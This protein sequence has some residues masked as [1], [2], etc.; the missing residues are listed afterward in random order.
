MRLSRQCREAEVRKRSFEEVSVF[1]DVLW[2]QLQIL[3]NGLALG[4]I[5]IKND[6]AT[7]GD[8]GD[9]DLP[10][11][12]L[13]DLEN[14]INASQH[15]ILYDWSTLTF[16]TSSIK[17]AHDHLKLSASNSSDLLFAEPVT[18]GGD[19]VQPHPFEVLSL[20]H[21]RDS[22]GIGFGVYSDTAARIILSHLHHTGFYERLDLRMQLFDE[23]SKPQTTF[24][25]FPL[26]VGLDIQ[27]IR[28]LASYAQILAQCNGDQLWPATADESVI[29]L[30]FCGVY[31]IT[32]DDSLAAI[33][34]EYIAHRQ[35][36]PG[37]RSGVDT[38]PWPSSGSR[39]A[40]TR[41]G[42]NGGDYVAYRR[43]LSSKYAAKWMLALHDQ[44]PVFYSAILYELVA[45][46][47]DDET[48]YRD[49]RLD[50][51]SEK[52]DLRANASFADAA[53]RR[54]IRLCHVGL[55]FTAFDDL[56]LNWLE[57]TS[58]LW[59]SYEAVTSL[60]RL[61]NEGESNQRSTTF[62][63]STKTV[64]DASALQSLNPWGVVVR[65][66][67]SH[68]D[69]LQR[70]L[71]WLRMFARS[72]VDIPIATVQQFASLANRH[73]LSLIESL[74]LTA[75][76]LY[77]TWLRSLGRQELLAVV[78]SL[79]VRLAPDIVQN[80]ITNQSLPD[81][82]S[83][84]RH[85]L[86]TILLLAGCERQSLITNG[87][88]LENEVKDLTPRRRG[89]TR[90]T[91]VS[92]PVHLRPEFV[93]ILGKYVDAGVE[94]ISILIAKFLSLFVSECRL[95]ESYE[96]DNFILRNCAVLCSCTWAFYGLQR[97]EL[98]DVRPVLFL[99]VLSVDSQPFESILQE[100]L[101]PSISWERR[102][103][104]IRR[105]FSIILDVTNQKFDVDDRQWRSS[106]ISVFDRFFTSMWQDPQEEIRI[107][108]DAWSQTLLP[109][110]FDAIS[111][112]WNECL[113]K[114]PIADRVKLLAFLIQL[115]PHF[116]ILSWEGIVETLLEDD[117]LQKHGES[118]D[119]PAAAY[120]SMYGLSSRD[121]VVEPTA[122]DSDTVALR[123][124]LLLLSMRMIA[125]GIPID[126]YNLLKI[127]MHLVES[128]GF[129]DA[130]NVPSSSGITFHISF[131]KLLFI[132][133]YSWPCISELFFV[134]DAPHPLAFAPSAMRVISATDEGSSTL[135]IGSI[136]VD[137]VLTLWNVSEDILSLPFLC[138]KHLLEALV[139]A[140]YKHDMESPP[141][142]HL[143]GSLRR[144]VR[145]VMD[146][147]LNKVSY[148]IR[149]LALS[150]A[151]AYAKR[152]PSAA[153]GFVVDSVET[154]SQLLLGL[155]Y[156][157]EDVLASQAFSVLEN[158]LST[159]AENG[160]LTALCKRPRSTAFFDAL[161]HVTETETLRET[162]LRDALSRLA[163]NDIASIQTV[164]D[165]LNVYVEVVH[166]DGYSADLLQH[167]GLSLTNVVRRTAECN[168]E[169]FDPSPILL[170]V[171]T[172]LENNKHFSHELLSSLEMILRATLIRFHISRQ[173]L[174]R[175]LE[176]VQTIRRK[177][178][179]QA[180]GA[181]HNLTLTLIEILA[182]GL[183]RKTRIPTVTIG[184]LTEALMETLVAKSGRTVEAFADIAIRL[185]EDGLFYLQTHSVHAGQVDAEFH[186]S[187]AVAK[188][189]MFGTQQRTEIIHRALSEQ[190]DKT[191]RY[192]LS[193]RAWNIL[194]LC[195]LQTKSNDPG[196]V[197]LS[198]FTTFVQTFR[199]TLTPQPRSA[200]LLNV[201]VAADINS[202]Y[203]G[204]KLWLLLE[205]KLSNAVED[206]PFES[207]AKPSDVGPFMIWNELWPSFQNLTG[208]YGLDLQGGQN[209]GI[210]ISFVGKES[211]DVE[212][213]EFMPHEA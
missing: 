130:A 144:A 174:V 60:S 202:G 183:R 2:T 87:L 126:V 28:L 83:F 210:D 191:A 56:F 34:R 48:S 22:L 33:L 97:D 186:A 62:I 74:P 131:Q 27:R 125:S 168:P 57:S 173:S 178:R 90:A 29:V 73:K 71:W 170:F 166:R 3:E 135:L 31:L 65:S 154:L 51:Q 208:M 121:S 8:D 199:D 84:L 207:S 161:R 86:A 40:Q 63:D 193:V 44:D 70:D 169:T 180:T 95:L 117:Y 147:A 137:V 81:T 163:D 80:T 149:Q 120:L 103:Q 172:L 119:G 12:E 5:V 1:S 205:R 206:D 134:L 195:A 156:N 13:H 132:P 61:F 37:V 129:E 47:T 110:H 78:C 42:N 176:V 64:V 211:E 104:A 111:A 123:V 196:A 114:A 185:A 162:L 108:V 188:L 142:K 212:E 75:T 140:I 203:A 128:M 15:T 190:L 49:I 175:L 99:R 20:A 167:A 127:K 182:D 35:M 141:L 100:S 152:W 85:S 187:I 94:D 53:L 171:C 52:T 30:D 59:N 79:H 92:D 201:T 25:V 32:Q 164:I 155:A 41:A 146:I 96:V 160:I 204:I 88:V 165:N 200:G 23:P 105:L 159:F 54:I 115:Q 122:E 116:P 150:V 136:F 45:E 93:S 138:V 91:M 66:A 177:D 38:Q 107:G 151:Q 77:L 113:S 179:R 16:I 213:D 19:D 50:P 10:E 55:V 6:V 184:A 17:T 7:D 58:S 157:R 102:L 89:N 21:L 67:S 69:G 36:L 9:D 145:K 68:A 11:F 106:I 43:N 153:G 197:L 76:A 24:C 133:G 118:G 124:S 112:C 194:L 4:S 82:I 143:Q 109:A 26:P 198:H 192:P 14:R 72:A 189:V 209:S 101:Q 39:L 148:E 139:V 98:T 46:I 181:M 158:S 18:T